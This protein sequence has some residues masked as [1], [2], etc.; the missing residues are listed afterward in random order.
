MGQ[1]NPNYYGTFFSSPQHLLK[2]QERVGQEVEREV[3]MRMKRAERAEES[4]TEMLHSTET[5]MQVSDSFQCSNSD[6]C[7]H[8]AS[9]HSHIRHAIILALTPRRLFRIC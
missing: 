7:Q 2:E 4:L 9:V 1:S 8:T 3:E 6:I 5:N